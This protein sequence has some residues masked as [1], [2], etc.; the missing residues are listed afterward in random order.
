[1][2]LES[3]AIRWLMTSYDISQYF[4]EHFAMFHPIYKTDSA[5]HNLAH[6][7]CR[8]VAASTFTASAGGIGSG[9]PG[10][11][12]KLSNSCPKEKT[13]V[14]YRWYM[15]NIRKIYGWYMLFDDIQAK[16]EG[17]RTHFCVEKEGEHRSSVP[18]PLTFWPTHIFFVSAS[19][20]ISGGHINCQRP[21]GHVTLMP[22]SLYWFHHLESPYWC[23]MGIAFSVSGV[24]QHGIGFPEFSGVCP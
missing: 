3:S 13:W 16:H 21:Y 4:T 11:P 9:A 14:I 7:R 2:I 17:H 18:T 6:L 24:L 23:W 12:S 22:A 8:P 15:E 5:C 19:T 10:A 1:M 20:L